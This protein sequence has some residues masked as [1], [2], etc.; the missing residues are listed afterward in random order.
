RLLVAGQL[1]SNIGDAFYAVALPWY[2][3]AD[4]GGALL[5]G[6][7]L[8]AYGLP[9]TLFLAFGGHAADRW[10][11]WVV[12]LVADAV[13]AIAV[14][15]LA[16]VA[17][18][19]PA[20]P[21]LVVPVAALLGAGEG[22]FLPGSFAIVPSILADEDLQAGNALSSGGTQLA[23]LIG[24]ALGG[25]V[26]ALFGPAPA[27]AVDAL[28]FL[29]STGTLAGIRRH[30]RP[31]LPLS[32]VA[33]PADAVWQ[34]LATSAAHSTTLRRLVASERVFQVILLVTIAA[35]LGSGGMSE[36]ALP[37][38]AHGPWHAGAGGYGGLM[39]AFGGGA[40]GGTL[41]AAQ[42]RRARRPAIL[43]SAAFLSEAL[44][45]AVIPY[46]GGAL[47]AAVA[48]AGF[49]A[50]NGFG[51]VVAITAFQRWAPGALMGRLMSLLML[52][53]FGVF[54]ASVMLGG[55]VVRSF[56]A[57]VFFPAAAAG[58]AAA[59]LVGLAQ[60]SWRDFGASERVPV[61]S[62]PRGRQ[63]AASQPSS[64]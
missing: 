60:R 5:L 58:L 62:R 34:P 59:V 23:T 52:A 17:V 43:A 31:A 39:A 14:A 47:A 9:R 36:V 46:L 54:P 37:A 6:G 19:G 49:G 21:A 13:R 24:P 51:N 41:I 57:A 4:H 12:M 33:A 40:L 3:L 2:V 42:A 29:V 56:G 25:A 16:G 27:F 48:L 22:L 53:S 44:F 30:R 8:A 63:G 64:S 11:P 20:A 32:P 10:R 45:M 18:S 55:V 35:N 28:S 26:V 50:F 61:P 15:A 1:A 7:V 38:L